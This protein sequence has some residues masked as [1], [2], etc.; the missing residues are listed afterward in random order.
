[1]VTVAVDEGQAVTA[2]PGKGPPVATTSGRVKHLASTSGIP[3]L[4]PGWVWIP[5]LGRVGPPPE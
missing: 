5:E 2:D 3:P 1:V 4:P